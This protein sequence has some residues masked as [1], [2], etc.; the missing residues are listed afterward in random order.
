MLIE[1][2]SLYWKMIAA[3]GVSACLCLAAQAQGPS[4]ADAQSKAN[5]LG[6]KAFVQR[7]NEMPTSG[8][9]GPVSTGKRLCTDVVPVVPNV[10]QVVIEYR[11]LSFK[12]V[13]D[14]RT[15]ADL[16]NEEWNWS[17]FA[18]FQVFRLRHIA[19][20]TWGP[21]TKWQNRDKSRDATYEVIKLRYS[22][23]DKWTWESGSDVTRFIQGWSIDPSQKLA[24]A[25]ILNETQHGKPP[26]PLDSIHC[27]DSLNHAVPVQQVLRE[28]A[29]SW[30]GIAPQQW[31]ELKAS[32]WKGLPGA[33][34]SRPQPGRTTRAVQPSSVQNATVAPPSSPPSP[35]S[36]AIEPSPG[37]DAYTTRS[38]PDPR[39]KGPGC[40]IE[41][42][43]LVAIESVNKQ[44]G[45]VE[46]H[47]LPNS[48]RHS[49]DCT[50]FM[51][52]DP[53]SLRVIEGY[54]S[55]K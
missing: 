51:T 12:A 16:A 46:V 32:D 31:D 20:G 23:N 33:K 34:Q 54:P 41:E 52:V 45:T 35:A 4:D 5:E 6:D 18:E 47:V 38:F 22:K 49:R 55:P 25:D 2:K 37:K 17:V 24:L 48:K 10:C 7:F 21:W 30:C 42:G 11:D 13:A 19:D 28:D 27:H 40:E 43:T 3:W 1:A 9:V 14:T 8:Y 29:L 39:G 50:N 15:P 53:G 36:T 26:G 44:T